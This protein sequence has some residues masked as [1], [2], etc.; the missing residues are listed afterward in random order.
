MSQHKHGFFIWYIGITVLASGASEWNG[1]MRGKIRSRFYAVLGTM[2][3]YNASCSSLLE[4]FLYPLTTS[5]LTFPKQISQQRQAENWASNL[6]MYKVIER[7]DW[8]NFLVA[9]KI[10]CVLFFSPPVHYFASTALWGLGCL[11]ALAHAHACTHT[12]TH[13]LIPLTVFAINS[14]PP[15]IL[16]QSIHFL[17]SMVCLMQSTFP[18]S[19]VLSPN[20]PCWRLVL[21]SSPIPCLFF[22]L[23]YCQH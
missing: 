13:F 22:K 5:L 18:L 15:S 10:L 1:R 2:N 8:L 20:K 21:A 14:Q 19:S 7:G 9:F 23:P 12:R 11:Y 16:V 17:C 6:Y 3:E 4:K